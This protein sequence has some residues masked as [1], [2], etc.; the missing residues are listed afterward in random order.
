MLVE[1]DDIK[2]GRRR[3]ADFA[4]LRYAWS[5]DKG[6]RLESFVAAARSIAPTETGDPTRLLRFARRFVSSE[7]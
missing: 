3:A 7:F 2:N 4:F 6:G 5:R 1:I